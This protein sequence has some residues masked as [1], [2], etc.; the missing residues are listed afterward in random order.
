MVTP[1]GSERPGNVPADVAVQIQR[2]L[3]HELQHGGGG[4]R[5]RH[6][7]DAEE[8]A[9]GIDRRV[10]LHSRQAVAAQQEHAAV[11][12]DRDRRPGAC[13]SAM[14]RRAHESTTSG[15]VAI[16]PGMMPSGGPGIAGAAALSV[17]GRGAGGVIGNVRRSSIE[18]P[19]IASAESA[20]ISTEAAQGRVPGEGD[21][22]NVRRAYIM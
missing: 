12:D 10:R 5:L 18:G 6:R 17:S 15:R 2:A 9:A 13:N 11:M 20:V 21:I 3:V 1:Y 16:A 14:S 7:P 8:R 22:G 4:E 19:T